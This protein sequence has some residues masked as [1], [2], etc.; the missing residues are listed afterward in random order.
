M[1]I[2]TDGYGTRSAENINMHITL[3]YKIYVRYQDTL[4]YI[5]HQISHCYFLSRCIQLVVFIFIQIFSNF[6]ING[7]FYA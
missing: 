7:Y 6:T 5:V 2:D 3:I 4:V 1:H